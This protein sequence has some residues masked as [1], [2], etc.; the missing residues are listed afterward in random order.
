M[1]TGGILIETNPGA[2][3]REH[4][5]HG[6]LRDLCEGFFDDLAWIERCEAVAAAD[7]P[8]TSRYLLAHEQHMTPRL[9]THHE[10]PL[11]LEVLADR[12]RGDHY[13]R[14]I[15]LTVEGSGAVAEFGI[16]RIDL[17]RVS[18]QA[19]GV[20]LEKQTPLGDVLAKHRVLTKVSPR[21]YLRFAAPSPIVDGLGSAAEGYGRLATIHWDGEAAVELLEV[22]PA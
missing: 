4:D 17:R 3:G 7:L 14:K 9:R 19:R 22:V 2:L 5:A 12:L 10:R 16:M 20:I 13:S 8:P 21:A 15:L 18:P 6:A 11:R 1:K